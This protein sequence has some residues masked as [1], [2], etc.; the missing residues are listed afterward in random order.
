MFLL[1]YAY[2]IR[3]SPV[4]HS[5]FSPALVECD[6][7][8]VNAKGG[9]LMHRKTFDREL[10]LKQILDQEKR[11]ILKRLYQDAIFEKLGRNY[12]N[13]FERGMDTADWSVVDAIQSLGVKLVDIRQDELVKMTQAQRKLEEGSYGIC[14]DC[15]LEI[16]EPRLA[17]MIYAIHCLE[18]AAQ[19]ELRRKQNE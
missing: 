5:E 1:H 12:K 8:R 15:G 10:K 2:F 18:C 6:R 11:K 17:A 19:N 4:L 14:E 13:E 9:G 16:S 3:Q 7:R